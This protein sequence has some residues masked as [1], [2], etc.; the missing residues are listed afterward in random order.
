MLK[1]KIIQKNSNWIFVTGRMVETDWL[2]PCRIGV[3]YGDCDAKEEEMYMEISQ[4]I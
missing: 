2:W 3:V 1:G 4:I